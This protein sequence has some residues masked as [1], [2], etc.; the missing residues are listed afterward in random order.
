MY[1]EDQ[2]APA[3]TAYAAIFLLNRA[4]LIARRYG[5]F[6]KML[7]PKDRFI[8]WNG[9]AFVV[10]LQRTGACED[11][12]AE[13]RSVAS[14]GRSQYFDVGD[15]SVLLDTSLTWTVFPQAD[16][17]SAARAIQDRPAS[18]AGQNWRMTGSSHPRLYF[19]GSS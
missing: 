19:T 5:D 10:L 9:D 3:A 8:H 7:M 18:A 11:V 4:D 2:P 16:F 13:L 14:L 12:S 6:K 17:A 15:R 1:L